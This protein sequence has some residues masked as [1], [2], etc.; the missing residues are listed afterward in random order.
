MEFSSLQ[1]SYSTA[2]IEESL[3]FGSTQHLPTP[4]PQL[5][6]ITLLVVNGALMSLEEGAYP[7]LAAPFGEHSGLLRL[8]L[9]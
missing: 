5:G 8:I 7:G 6:Q 9:D 3:F 4:A 1:L 2:D